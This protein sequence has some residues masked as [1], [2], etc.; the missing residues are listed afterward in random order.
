MLWWQITFSASHTSHRTCTP[1]HSEPSQHTLLSVTM[2]P[3]I[4]ASLYAIMSF[5]FVIKIQNAQSDTFSAFGMIGYVEFLEEKETDPFIYM[6]IKSI[7]ALNIK[8][9]RGRWVR[10]CLMQTWQEAKNLCPKST[11]AKQKKKVL[12]MI[13]LS[14]FF[15]ALIPFRHGMG[16]GLFN[17]V[18]FCIRLDGQFWMMLR[19]HSHSL[20][21]SMNYNAEM[22]TKAIL[23][24]HLSQRI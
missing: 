1:A 10:S 24:G 5:L 14:F 15:R 23:Q 11:I 18:D 4:H 17:K 12:L 7:H 3:D 22:L 6:L 21:F 9:C 20:S 13:W 19:W 2:S 8:A 16:H